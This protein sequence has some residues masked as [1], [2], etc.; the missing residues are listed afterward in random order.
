MGTPPIFSNISIFHVSTSPIPDWIEVVRSETIMGDFQGSYFQVKTESAITAENMVSINF[1]D[2]SGDDIGFLA[3]DTNQIQA[4]SSCY[5][6]VSVS[7][8]GTEGG[9]I[10][11]FLKSTYNVTV[12]F[13]GELVVQYPYRYRP[14]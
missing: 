1:L 5:D 14:N 12:W 3:T 13:E 9:G 8:A 7:H 2:E 4:G 10:W 6:E 11:T